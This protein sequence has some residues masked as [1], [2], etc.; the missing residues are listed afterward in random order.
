MS[1]LRVRQ[2]DV[3]G[4]VGALHHHMVKMSQVW[5]RVWSRLSWAF[6]ALA[7][8][9]IV[10]LGLLVISNHSHRQG[11]QSETISVWTGCPVPLTFSCH[12]EIFL[13][14]CIFSSSNKFSTSPVPT[15][16]FTV[17]FRFDALHLELAQTHKTSPASEGPCISSQHSTNLEISTTSVQI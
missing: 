6:C 10:A 8:K 16:Y 2:Q 13:Q 9:S 11:C 3:E 7:I 5:I 12:P 17:Q 4:R 15:S 14:C 1:V